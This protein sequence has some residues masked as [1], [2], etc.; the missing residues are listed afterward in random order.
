MSL[1]KFDRIISEYENKTRRMLEG[2]A[3]RPWMCA[4]A[5]GRRRPRTLFAD[6]VLEAAGATLREMN[7]L[8]EEFMKCYYSPDPGSGY[9]D[10]K[11]SFERLN[12]ENQSGGKRRLKYHYNGGSPENTP[13]LEKFDQII[14]DYKNKTR[15]FFGMVEHWEGPRTLFFDDVFNGV[16]RF[17]LSEMNEL[18]EEFMKCHY[19]P[20]PGKGYLEAKDSFEKLNLENQ[21][22]GKRRLKYHYNGGSPENTPSLEKFDQI[23]S[24][25]ENKTLRFWERI[26]ANYEADD[27]AACRREAERLQREFALR[28]MNELRQEFIKCH[29]SP[30]PGQG[31][32]DIKDRFER[33]NLENQ[34]DGNKS[35]SKKQSG[36]APKHDLFKVIKHIHDETPLD[37]VWA[38][39]RLFIA[40]LSQP[41]DIHSRNN[42][43]YSPLSLAVKEL[44]VS[45]VK[46]LLRLGANPNSTY[47]GGSRYLVHYL[48]NDDSV[49]E[50]DNLE[51][52]SDDEYVRLSL[53]KQKEI[54]KLLLINGANVNEI[55]TPGGYTPLHY[56]VERNNSDLVELLLKHGANTEIKAEMAFSEAVHQL[57]RLER[58]AYI[59]MPHVTPIEYLEREKQFWDENFS[60]A[61]SKSLKILE[62]HESKRETKKLLTDQLG[63]TLLLNKDDPNNNRDPD[64]TR[65]HLSGHKNKV[66][67]TIKSYYGGKGKKK[68]RKLRKL[69]KLK[70]KKLK[71]KKT[72]KQASPVKKE[73]PI[74][75]IGYTKN[76]EC[77]PT[78]LVLP[79]F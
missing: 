27:E 52:S 70:S 36:G 48:A 30:N 51:D 17:A 68:T 65:P 34:S 74:H 5:S 75:C 20:N 7:E 43:G 58:G 72:V 73:L 18:R 22:G 37:P 62:K 79:F 29:Y 45:M 71:S 53:S 12:L 50:N 56:A 77:I 67:N 21:S 49:L 63:R 10:A 24:D 11:D 2:L 3:S 6:T 35:K 66:I 44:D 26:G 64:D 13:S 57:L 33:R 40:L 69:K 76:K 23:I 39:K 42:N 1:E 46:M 54:M 78:G 15:R 61:A 16:Y 55:Q 4:T 41:V 60:N 9:L 59:N 47:R 14:S 28:E 8:R 25:Y 38:K 32:L 19:S 31:Y